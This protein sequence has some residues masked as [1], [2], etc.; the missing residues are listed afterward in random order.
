MTLGLKEHWLL[1]GSS[2][3]LAPHKLLGSG[4]LEA[5]TCCDLTV[6]LF[7]LIAGLILPILLLVFWCCVSVPVN[8][9]KPTFCSCP[10]VYP[11]KSGF[12]G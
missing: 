7:L 12:V 10:P 5:W 2:L 1:P 11:R 9:Q 3:S 4:I 6:E 8:Q